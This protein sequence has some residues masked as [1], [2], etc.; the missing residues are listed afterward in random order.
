MIYNRQYI[1]D[2]EQWD[3]N[4]INFEQDIT[5]NEK[6]QIMRHDEFWKQYNMINTINN[7]NSN[8]FW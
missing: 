7:N 1:T 3:N 4:D 5:N 2:D 6:W 8:D